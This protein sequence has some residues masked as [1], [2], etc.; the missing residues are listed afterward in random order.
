MVLD[1]LDLV[2]DPPVRPLP[3]GGLPAPVHRAWRERRPA[4]PPARPATLTRSRAASAPAPGPEQPPFDW[5]EVLLTL[6]RHLVLPAVGHGAEVAA[7]GTTVRLTR[8]DGAP[9]VLTDPASR[10]RAH[11]VLSGHRVALDPHEVLA[12]AERHAALRP[13]LD[14]HPPGT[15]P[16]L[17]LVLAAAGAGLGAG[18]IAAAHAAGSLTPEGVALLA[19]LGGGSRAGGAPAPRTPHTPWRTSA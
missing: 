9:V 8:L 7:L 18:E 15:P 12:L 6:H 2:A 14:A 5:P 19:A 17:R 11:R 16:G 4:G 13:F 1:A 10:L 3:H